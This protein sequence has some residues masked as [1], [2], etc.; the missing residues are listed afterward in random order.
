MQLTA[1][2]THPNTISVYDYGRTPEG[3]FYYA[4]ELLEGMTSKSSVESTGPCPLSSFIILRQVCGALQEAH[5]SGLIHRDVKP[6]NI[7]LCRQR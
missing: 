6:A 3:T 4:M 2:L 1:R 7:Y 5:G